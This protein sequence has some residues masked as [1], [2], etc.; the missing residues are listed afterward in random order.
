MWRLLSTHRKR[1]FTRLLRM[2]PW[3]HPIRVTSMGPVVATGHR[4]N[5]IGLEIGLQMNH[6]Q[7]ASPAL[8]YAI[9]KCIRVVWSSHSTEPLISEWDKNESKRKNQLGGK[10]PYDKAPLSLHLYWNIRI[11]VAYSMCSNLQFNSGCWCYRNR[12]PRKEPRRI[13]LAMWWVPL[14]FTA[15]RDFYSIMQIL[16]AYKCLHNV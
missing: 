9:A 15:K 1:K 2:S 10:T 3:I 6:P 8:D 16:A 7:L 11:C 12:P 14:I 4:N 13:L 5:K